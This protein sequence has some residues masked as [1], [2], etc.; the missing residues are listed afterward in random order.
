[1]IPYAYNFDLDGE[2]NYIDDGGGDDMYDGGNYLNTN[3]ESEFNYSDNT[4]INST[5]FGTNGKYFT[6]KVNTACLLTG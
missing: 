6:R 2:S 3:Y 5:A 4:I 1:M